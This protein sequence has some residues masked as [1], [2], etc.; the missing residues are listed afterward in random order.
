[1]SILSEQSIGSAS[2]STANIEERGRL[3]FKV[4]QE[5]AQVGFGGF[6][7]SK[8]QEQYELFKATSLDKRTMPNGE[9][10]LNQGNEYQY[11]PAVGTARIADGT[12]TLLGGMSQMLSNPSFATWVCFGESR[13]Q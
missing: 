2:M 9:T 8:D 10:A 4:T 12:P 13:I 1:M 6:T 7:Y 5:E 11:G 3:P